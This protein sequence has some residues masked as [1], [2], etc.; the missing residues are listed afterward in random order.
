MQKVK[1]QEGMPINVIIGLLIS[2]A[3]ALL[4]AILVFP[5]IR[6]TGDAAGC[7]GLLRNLASI[8]SDMT[9]FSMC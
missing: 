6:N 1:G 2:I 4:F 7:A 5:A 9:G 8:I 3:V